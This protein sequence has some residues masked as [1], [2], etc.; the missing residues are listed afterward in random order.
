M[1]L[2]AHHVLHRAVIP[3]DLALRHRVVGSP[4]RV[5]E[6]V[7]LQVGGQ[8]LRHVAGAVV[9]EQARL[10]L[11]SDPIHPRGCTREVQRLGHVLHPHR[12]LAALLQRSPQVGL[13]ARHVVVASDKAVEEAGQL[14]R[15]LVSS[16]ISCWPKTSTRGST[17]PGREVRY[18]APIILNE[19]RIRDGARVVT[20]R[21]YVPGA[22]V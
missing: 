7:L 11:D 16:E 18:F 1:V 2:E 9:A 13:A 10:V 6:P 14:S 17:V 20:S 3:L 15:L 22:R 12:V 21:F 8:V 4:P 5:P 19:R